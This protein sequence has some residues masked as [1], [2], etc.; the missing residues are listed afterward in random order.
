MVRRRKKR[1]PI[2]VCSLK[3]SGLLQRNPRNAQAKMTNFG[4][5][6]AL[7]FIIFAAPNKL[8]YAYRYFY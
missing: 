4:N 3:N 6:C 7:D 8:H 1:R 5:L 2:A